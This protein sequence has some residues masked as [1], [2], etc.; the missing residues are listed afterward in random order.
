MTSENG[1]ENGIRDWHWK[2]VQKTASENGF[3]KWCQKT[4]SENSIRKMV[5]ENM[6]KNGVRKCQ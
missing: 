6:S 1:F 4:A 3:R 5:S 2:T